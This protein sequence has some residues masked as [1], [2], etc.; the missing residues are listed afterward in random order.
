MRR[1][2]AAYAL[3][4]ALFASAFLAGCGESDQGL[5]KV[6]VYT[7][8]DQVYAERIIGECKELGLDVAAAFDSEASKT[9]GLFKRLIEERDRPRADVFWNN[10]ACRTLQLVES[11]LAEDLSDLVPDNF[12]KRWV[13]PNGRWVAFSLRARVLVFNTKL[14]A[15]D[16]V[17]RTLAEL[18]QPKW[19]GKV[20]MANPLF[21]TTA[22]HMAALYEAMGEERAEELFRSLKANGVRI[23]EGN[24]VVRDVVARGEVPVG[25]TDTD[26]VFAGMEQGMEIDFVLPDQNGMGTLTIPNTVMIVKGG[27]NPEGARRFVQFLL[28]PKVEEMLAFERARQIPVRDDI[29]R[30]DELKRLT[31]IKSM[32]VDY[33]NVAARMPDTALRVEEIFLK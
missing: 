24:S 2:T 6:V 25:L 21:G 29:P 15:P 7:S 22:T 4:L 27:P 28:S 8:V 3:G 33:G 19:K 13:D 23:M 32:A 16:E 9:T 11:G 10:E 1:K 20:A 12:P 5:S 14:V 26:D 17:P 31:G 30:P 18:T